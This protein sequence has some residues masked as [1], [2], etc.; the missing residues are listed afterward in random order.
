M[1]RVLPSDQVHG[2]VGGSYLCEGYELRVTLRCVSEDLDLATD[3]P[4]EKPPEHD[5]IGAFVD[6]WRDGLPEGASTVPGL[7]L[8][9]RVR[10]LGR[11][12]AIWHDENAKAAWLVAYAEE[13][14]VAYF[15][16]LDAE[17]RL[18]PTV[19]DYEALVIDRDLR[20]VDMVEAEAARVLREARAQVGTEQHA[21]LDID[22]G[23]S[24]TIERADDVERIY[25]AIKPWDRPDDAR[26]HLLFGCFFSGST[27]DD[28]KV[29]DEVPGRG[30]RAPDEMVYC[31]WRPHREADSRR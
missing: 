10:R 9:G 23:I 4:F 14:S 25:L 13:A 17:G 21:E 16:E 2:S 12:G 11:G 30:E 6:E 8:S 18:K 22:T 20:F 5:V 3:Q 26:R 15:R 29:V 7:T 27:L 31:I 1:P 24:I 28:I 19:E